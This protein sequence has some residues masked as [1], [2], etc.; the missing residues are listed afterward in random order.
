MGNHGFGRKTFTYEIDT[1]GNAIVHHLNGAVSHANF[2]DKYAAAIEG[3]YGRYTPFVD[4]MRAIIDEHPNTISLIMFDFDGPPYLCGEAGRFHRVAFV[5]LSEGCFNHHTMAH[6]LA[7]VFGLKHHDIVDDVLIPNTYTSEIMLRSLRFAEWL[8]VSRYLNTDK[9][10]DSTGPSTIQML[11]PLASPPNAVRLRFEVADPDG[12]Y[13]AQLVVVAVGGGDTIACKRLQ[14]D[15]TIVEFETAKIGPLL[16]FH[17][18]SLLVIDETGDISDFHAGTFPIDI[19]PVL[20]S[21]EAISIPDPNLARALRAQFGLAYNS[22]ITHL[23]MLKISSL[24]ISGNQI[25]DLT[26]LEYA[27]N[28]KQLVSTDNQIQ[29]ITPIIALKQ[30]KYLI[31]GNNQ[32]NDI[33]SLAALT[34]LNGLFINGNQISDIT[35]LAKLP[36]LINLDLSDNKIS[37]ISP[38][39]ELAS[40]RY[41]WLE[42]NKISDV[43]PLA[44]LTNL[45]TLHLTGNPIKDRKPLF[46]L[47]EKNPN[48]KIYL[49]ND[50]EPLPVNLSHF[51]AEHTDAGVILNWT[52]ESEVDNAGFYIYRS[53]TRD[54]EFKVVNAT[55]IQGAGTTG[56]RN[57]YTW[58]DD[59]A[60]PNTV[61]YYRIE[62]VSHAG[63]R[64]QL[65]TV[66]LRGLISAH[67]KLTTSWA[68]LKTVE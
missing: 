17:K 38:L 9:I 50:R 12:L 5:K 57:E 39:S 62:D 43:G 55:I 67:G 23:D 31:L 1:D 26:G 8:N 56:E 22:E 60:Q 20:P 36:L 44:K 40:L 18:V 29:D 65:A 59:T 46:E 53:E 54:G 42:N 58:T 47:L 28:L 49:K 11:S 34:T 52:T 37:D 66:R 27:T 51:R 30:L 6:E 45:E 41:V 13:M 35:P 24:Q 15:K 16:E 63:V 7:H 19:T 14:G 25:T 64:E 10:T 48:I 61:Y 68:D 21:S 3:I 4:E 33:T 32:I 2:H